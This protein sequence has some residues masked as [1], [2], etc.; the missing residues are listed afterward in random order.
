M[1]FSIG[2][3]SFSAKLRQDALD[4]ARRCFE[5]GKRVGIGCSGGAD[6]LLL[7]LI[8][9]EVFADHVDK[10]LVLHFNHKARPSADADEKYV[11]GVCLKLGV[12]AIVGSADNPPKKKTEAEF[13]A[14]RLKFFEEACARENIA[15][16]LQAHHADDAAE[17]VLMRLSR[18]A[19]LDGLR[20][21]F[22]I[23]QAG[24][25]RFARPLLDMRKS[26][27]ISILK[28]AGYSW[29]EDETNF[30][31][32]HFRNKMRLRVL[33]VLEK[34][35]KGFVG[36][37]RRSQMLLCE[38]AQ[39]IN[40]VA[41]PLVGACC[42]TPGFPRSMRLSGDILARRAFIRRA[43]MRFLA[44]NGLSEKMR[45]SAVDKFVESVY[46]SYSSN[47]KK[48]LKVSAG[49][50][51]IVYSPQ[52]FSLYISPS[53]NA[54][55]SLKTGLGEVILPSGL[56]FAAR[57]I[58]LEPEQKRLLLEGKND[59]STRAVLDLS[60]AAGCLDGDFLEIRTRRDGDA[61]APIGSSSPKR[62]KALLS[63]KKVPVVQR[64][65]IFVVCNCNGE[66]LWAP[67]IGPA[68]KYKIADSTEVLELTLKNKDIQ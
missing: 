37:V 33:P 36:G 2:K 51:I 22:P 45:A 16:I 21:P 9:S 20:A 26:E 40:S 38:D 49:E 34:V 66:I 56:I 24:A 59:D 43:L 53:S 57:R 64:K 42:Q 44:S 4:E 39:A 8:C 61:Y 10:L 29:C 28:S 14:M 30:E 52:D 62:L 23:S 18:G 46:G 60:A 58:N 41:E 25:L 15:V 1:D 3:Y 32:C 65:S 12:S 13:R 17:S 68:S 27:I 35:A 48:P 19:G 63:G 6:S 50:N 31:D 67:P 55:F 54:C 11:R 5:S 7:L 47:G